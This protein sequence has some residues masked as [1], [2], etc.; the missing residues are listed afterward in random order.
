MGFHIWGKNKFGEDCGFF[1]YPPTDKDRPL[2]KVLGVGYLKE[3]SK[4]LV[5]N[6]SIGDL[7]KAKSDLLPISNTLSEQDFLDKCLLSSKESNNNPITITF[8]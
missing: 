4:E 6:Y 7:L 1:H 5:R 2:H 3:D 8:N